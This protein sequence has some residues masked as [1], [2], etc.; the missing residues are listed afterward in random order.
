[1][2]YGSPSAGVD[3]LLNLEKE[4]AKAYKIKIFQVVLF[5]LKHVQKIWCFFTKCGE[6][7][8]LF[9]HKWTRTI[10]INMV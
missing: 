4:S 1:M 10:N 6:L 3:G 8:Q 5:Y 7:V 9:N 2:G